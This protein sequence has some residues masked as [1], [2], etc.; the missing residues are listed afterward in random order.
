MELYYKQGFNDRTR[1]TRDS[2]G[3][4]KHFNLW[5]QMLRRCYVVGDNV[6]KTY[7]FCEVGENFK[8][9]SYF[10]DWCNSQKGF[11]QEGYQ[12]DKDYLGFNQRVY[13]EDT[14]V[15]IPRRLN[16]FLVNMR[17]D[18]DFPFLGVKK[19]RGGR[20]GSRIRDGDSR[21]YLGCFNNPQD[22]QSEYIAKKSIIA[23]ELAIKYEGLVDERVLNILWNFKPEDYVRYN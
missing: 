21:Y 10:F 1:P 23:K 16:G 5:S 12:L 22:A 3:S 15:F 8:R 13:S 19:E 20:F 4:I 18:K 9:Y 11:N 6:A 14:C 2:N 17:V 7:E